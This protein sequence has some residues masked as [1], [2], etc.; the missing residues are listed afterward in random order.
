[1]SSAF[2]HYNL[3]Q[4]LHRTRFTLVPCAAVSCRQVAFL[5]STNDNLF[6]QL[7]KSPVAAYCVERTPIPSGNN[8]GFAEY[9]SCNGPEAN[10]RNDPGDPICIC[11]V[12]PDRMIALQTAAEMNQACGPVQWASDG[13]HSSPPCNCTGA[14]GVVSKWSTPNTSDYFVSAMPAW[15]PYFYFQTPVRCIPST[16]PYR[17]TCAPP[18]QQRLLSTLVNNI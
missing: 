4:N 6:F 15:L 2:Q 1:V 13:S 11:N 8:E 14:D 5:S 16:Y 7:N 18:L 9:V 12:F 17:T 10:P 3:I